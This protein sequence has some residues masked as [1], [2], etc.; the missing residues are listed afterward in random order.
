M[1]PRETPEVTYIDDEEQEEGGEEEGRVDQRP[2]SIWAWGSSSHF[3]TPKTTNYSSFSRHSRINLN[4][5][6]ELSSSLK[7]QHVVI[8][9][10]GSAIA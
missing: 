1:S 9:L 10:N 6:I 7:V 5:H 4:R 2:P 3:G 8:V